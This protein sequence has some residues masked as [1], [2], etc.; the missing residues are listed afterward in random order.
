M[1][2]LNNKSFRIL[3]VDDDSTVREL[4]RGILKSSNPATAA[5]PNFDLTCCSQGDEAVEAV[6]VLRWQ[7]QLDP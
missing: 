3:A 2:E 5:I 4:Y 1:E 6:K 7:A